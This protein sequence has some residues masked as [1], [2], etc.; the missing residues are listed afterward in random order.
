MMGILKWVILAAVIAFAAYAALPI[1]L[2]MK[3]GGEWKFSERVCDMGTIIIEEEPETPEN[4][5][6]TPLE[7]EYNDLIRIDSP[8]PGTGISS[9]LTITGEARGQWFFEATFPI[10]IVNWDGLIIGEGY[11]EATDEW[12][13]TDYVPFTATVSFTFDP[14]TPYDRGW[15]IFQKSNASGLPEHDDAFEMPI[16]FN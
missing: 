16:T 7:N 8:L 4:P 6:E 11:A 12:M 5:A 2:C 1:A 14:A 10:T 3:D 13:T 9:P 15:I